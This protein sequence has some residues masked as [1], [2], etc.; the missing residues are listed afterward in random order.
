MF[1]PLVCLSAAASVLYITFFVSCRLNPIYCTRKDFAFLWLSLTPSLD[2]MDH[3][4]LLNKSKRPATSWY[5]PIRR[6]LMQAKPAEPHSLGRSLSHSWQKCLE[7]GK[8]SQ[9][10]K[11]GAFCHLPLN[12]ISLTWSRLRTIFDFLI[13][14]LQVSKYEKSIRFPLA[15]LH[16][17]HGR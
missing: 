3:L 11:W 17:I 14:L 12:L 8:V 2:V 15:V 9:K 6:V 13:S 1:V 4:F 7:C 10:L 16:F 5:P